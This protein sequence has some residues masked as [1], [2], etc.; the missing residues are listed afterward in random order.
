MMVGLLPF[1]GGVE[2]RKGGRIG[3]GR[4]GVEL[5]VNGGVED[6][7]RGIVGEGGMGQGCYLSMGCGP[8]NGGVEDRRGA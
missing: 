3:E 6:R 4:M 7:K 2:D 8:V 1:N 5:P